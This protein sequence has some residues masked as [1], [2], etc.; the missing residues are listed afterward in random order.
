MGEFDLDPQIEGATGFGW[1]AHFRAPDVGPGDG[2]R[3]VTQTVYPCDPTG[4]PT[5]YGC[6]SCTYTCWV[7]GNPCMC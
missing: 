1:E 4:T 2:H 3:N 7:T 6:A 5:P